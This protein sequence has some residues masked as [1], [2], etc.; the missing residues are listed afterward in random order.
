MKQAMVFAAGLGTRLRPLTD[1]MPKA[2]VPIAGEPLLGILLTKLHRAGF[3]R[4]VVNVHHFAEQIESY[5]QGQHFSG[6]E[7]LVSDERDAL[8]ETGGGLRRALPLLDP[9]APVLVHNVDILSNLDLEAFWQ[10][11]MAMMA[12]GAAAVL[13]VRERETSRYFLFDSMN[14]LRG[15]ENR[16]TGEVRTY[17][18]Q[19]PQ[20]RSLAFSGI[21]LLAPELL[22]SMADWPD[23]FPI[24]DFY[25]QQAPNYSIVADERADV[26][27]LDVG[28]V[29]SLNEAASMLADW[30]VQEKEN[31]AVALFKSGYTCSQAVFL[32]FAEDYGLSTQTALALASSFSGGVART[33]EMCGAVSGMLMVLGLKHPIDPTNPMSKQQNFQ[34]V[35]EAMASFRMSQGAIRCDE[36]LRLRKGGCTACVACAAKLS[37]AL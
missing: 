20:T 21:H 4:V 12:Q 31:T 34:C 2:L 17:E 18:K 29:A 16:K 36:L 24:V 6:M 13:L 28:K 14:H 23:Q 15:W 35:Q 32:A 37:A 10:D 30:K 25:L 7:I 22:Q 1:T 9:D 26:Q 11:G 3:E 33:G 5:L 19:V 8:L 27:L